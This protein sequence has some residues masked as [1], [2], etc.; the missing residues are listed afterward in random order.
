MISHEE[1]GRL[2]QSW[3]K[4]ERILLHENGNTIIEKIKSYGNKNNN[5]YN[6]KIFKLI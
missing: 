5:L 3:N 2:I 6:K 4:V 1:T